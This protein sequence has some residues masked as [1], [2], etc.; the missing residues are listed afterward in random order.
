MC[1]LSRNFKYYICSKLLFQIEDFISIRIMN[2]VT[3]DKNH[4]DQYYW[5]SAPEYLI[6]SVREQLFIWTSSMKS[7]VKK[8]YGDFL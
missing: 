8:N 3:Q 5:L 1:E 4:S 2:Y 6:V 7:I